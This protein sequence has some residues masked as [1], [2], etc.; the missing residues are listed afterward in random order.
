MQFNDD[1]A[2]SLTSNLSQFNGLFN[3]MKKFV[4]SI[5]VM[6]EFNSGEEKLVKEFYT[7]V[8]VENGLILTCY[9]D[10]EGLVGIGVRTNENFSEARVINRNRESGFSLLQ[11]L[12]NRV[13]DYV[14]LA[15]STSCFYP[16]EYVYSMVYPS[17]DVSPIILMGQLAYHYD[18][19]SNNNNLSSFVCSDFRT[20][21]D[22]DKNVY[23]GLDEHLSLLQIGGMKASDVNPT[24]N[25]ESRNNFGLNESRGAPVF[26]AVGKLIGLIIFQ[27]GGFDFAI[28]VKEIKIDQVSSYSIHNELFKSSKERRR[29]HGLRMKL[30]EFK[31]GMLIFAYFSK[32]LALFYPINSN[33]FYVELFFFFADKLF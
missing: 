8:S 13:Y 18:P 31:K 33:M 15:P 17:A 7:G 1:G 26:D 14:E 10:V 3:T 16:G 21:L 27:Q 22:L 25:F 5:M 32:Q 2:G 28:H 4:W 23:P 20:I 19:V 30:F 6:R 12:K 29:V 24:M 11:K 9:F